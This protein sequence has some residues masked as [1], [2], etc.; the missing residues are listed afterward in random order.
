MK[1]AEIAVL[2]DEVHNIM[3]NQKGADETLCLHFLA[4]YKGL[5]LADIQPERD[6]D[7]TIKVEDKDSPFVGDTLKQ[8]WVLRAGTFLCFVRRIYTIGEYE[9]NYFMVDCLLHENEYG[10]IFKEI[11]RQYK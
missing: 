6:P 8:T 2:A 3:G 5:S 1:L 10:G 4:L 9:N 11:V 7:F